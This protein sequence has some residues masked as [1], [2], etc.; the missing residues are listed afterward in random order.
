MVDKKIWQVKKGLINGNLL[1]PV[2]YYCE[3]Q[4]ISIIMC[5]TTIVC[6]CMCRNMCV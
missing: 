3:T 2:G 5:T 6:A 4:C 1:Y